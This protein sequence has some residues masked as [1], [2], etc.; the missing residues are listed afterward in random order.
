MITPADGRFCPAGRGY[1][2]PWYI[3]SIIAKG[4]SSVYCSE[5]R[6]RHDIDDLL[7]SDDLKEVE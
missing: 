5:C 7:D 1:F 2:N 4:E 3:R 6:R